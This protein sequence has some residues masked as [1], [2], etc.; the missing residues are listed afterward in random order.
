MLNYQQV[1]GYNFVNNSMNE[2]VSVVHTRII[3]DQK[4]FIVTA[5]PEIV[6]Y[7]QSNA[8]YERI[9]KKSDYVIPDGIGIVF[10]SKILGKP[11]Q[12]RLAGFD[13]ME[14]LLKLAN[15]NHYSV[16]LLG[17]KPHVIDLTALNI[18]RKYGNI[19]IVG[20]HHGY[21]KS[22]QAQED[23]IN[24]IK[25]RKPDLVFVG[26]G[27][28]KQEKWIAQNLHEFEKGIFMGIGGC[29]NV[30]AGVDKRAPKFWRT[31]NLEWLYRLIRQPSRSKRMFAIPVFLN[32]VFRHELRNNSFFARTLKFFDFLKNH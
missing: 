27:F 17:T 21:F 4:T 3:N 11:L 28:P 19:N 16:Y 12:E 32:R 6:T 8:S 7:A 20:Y 29:L 25:K 2:L 14:K 31:L 24:V 1:L 30:W 23:I 18:K 26:L 5:N 22:E 9:I 15:E 13:L 10:A